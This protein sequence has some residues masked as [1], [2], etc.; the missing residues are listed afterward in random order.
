MF[1]PPQIHWGWGFVAVFLSS[2]TTTENLLTNRLHMSQSGF[3]FY[4]NCLHLH[5]QHCLVLL[6]GEAR[7]LD[8]CFKNYLIF[9]VKEQTSIS[10]SIFE[11]FCMFCFLSASLLWGCFTISALLLGVDGSSFCLLCLC[12]RIATTWQPGTT[13]SVPCWA[14]ASPF[15]NT[16]FLL[17]SF[18]ATLS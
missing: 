9:F 10:I 6:Q 18:F 17:P 3:L 12:S 2:D 4:R 1:Y 5:S 13:M 16:T 8:A 15:S 11:C 7:Y 14:Q